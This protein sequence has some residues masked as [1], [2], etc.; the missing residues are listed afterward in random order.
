MEELRHE[1]EEELI[2][3]F[4]SCQSLNDRKEASFNFAKKTQDLRWYDDEPELEDKLQNLRCLDQLKTTFSK[5][6]H[7]EPLS[8]V[9]NGQP[10]NQ[11]ELLLASVPVGPPRNGNSKLTV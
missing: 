6:A 8:V 7:L 11:E 2:L 5:Y 4:K 10:I 9:Y 1:E 3:N